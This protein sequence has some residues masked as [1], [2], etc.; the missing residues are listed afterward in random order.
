[1]HKKCA[2]KRIVAIGAAGLVVM[3]GVWVWFSN[4]EAVIRI[5]TTGCKPFRWSGHRRGSASTERESSQVGCLLVVFGQV[6]PNGSVTF[7]EWRTVPGGSE[8]LPAPGPYTLQLLDG[9]GQEL[10]SVPF[11]G[12]WPVADMPDLPEPDVAAFQM[13]LDWPDKLAA[14]RVLDE[15]GD[16]LG[17]GVVEISRQDVRFK[18]AL[19]Y[20]TPKEHRA[21]LAGC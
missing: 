6:R 9:D 19:A 14:V 3:L 20:L 5:D 4:C 17:T 8:G 16:V 1:M 11:G 10:R 2:A 7:E 21:S 13:I 18:Q 12:P 15:R